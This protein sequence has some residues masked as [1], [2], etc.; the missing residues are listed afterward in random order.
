MKHPKRRH[1]LYNIISKA[2]GFCHP[3]SLKEINRKPGSDVHVCE[4]LPFLPDSDGEIR[5][6]GRAKNR[7][8]IASKYSRAAYRSAH[9][10]MK[11]NAGNTMAMRVG[12]R[13]HEAASNATLSK[14]QN[15]K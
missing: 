9:R 15:N 2:A 6:I 5:A 11:A 7:G 3:P 4:A 10:S 8:V 1:Q 14:A 13:H 12:K